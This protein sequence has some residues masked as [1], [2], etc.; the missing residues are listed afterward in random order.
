[1]RRRLFHGIAIAAA[2]VTVIGGI[3]GCG[4]VDQLSAKQKVSKAM[5][6]LEDADSASFTFR[7]DTTTS[8]IAAIAKANNDSLSANDRKVLGQ[9]IAGDIEYAVHAADGKKLSDSLNAF[10]QIPDAEALLKDPQKFGAYLKQAGDFQIAVHLS[11]DSLVELRLKDGV[12]YGRA[13]VPKIMELTG[14]D[15]TQIDSQ[16]ASLPAN[17][18]PIRKAAHGEWVSVDLTALMQSLKNSRALD[19]LPATATPS[20]DAGA[21]Q[22]LLTD[23]RAAYEQKVTIKELGDSDRGTQYQLSASAKQVA[24][25]VQDDVIK[26]AGDAAASDI[27]KSIAEIPDLPVNVNVWVKDDELTGISFDV[28]QFIDNKPAGAKLAVDVAVDVDSGDIEKPSGATPLDV[29]ALMNEVGASLS[30][31]GASASG[32]GFSEGFGDD[33]RDLGGEPAISDDF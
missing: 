15:S 20:V 5:S 27:R 18:A 10:K 19:Q 2:G 8:D 14:Q 13:A 29:R 31:A 11:G 25:A 6:S 9:V 4:A 30:G 12:I 7:L 33:S 23:L 26:I 1:M 24:A 17:L 21:V 16:L 32:S 3:A 22:K 28:A